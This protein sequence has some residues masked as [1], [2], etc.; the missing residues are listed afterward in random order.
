MYPS[1]KTAFLCIIL[2]PHIGS[3]QN[4]SSAT[5]QAAQG[6]IMSARESNTGS[7]VAVP[8]SAAVCEV[9]SAN[10]ASNDPK[11]SKES[12]DS[13]V[14]T[15]VSVANNT[16]V[17]NSSTKD[18]LAERVNTDVSVGPV[19]A[20]ETGLARLKEATATSDSDR[21]IGPKQNS[22]L[23]NTSK[24]AGATDSSSELDILPSLLPSDFT[25][26][27]VLKDITGDGSASGANEMLPLDVSEIVISCE[28][29]PVESD[30]HTATGMSCDAV[31][32]PSDGVAC[33]SDSDARSSREGREGSAMEDDHR[34]SFRRQSPRKAPTKST[35]LSSLTD[36]SSPNS[37]GMIVHFVQVITTVIIIITVV[38][39]FYPWFKF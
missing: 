26:D 14:T 1:L 38:A 3:E 2:F 25:L 4:V 33:D 24:S 37:S 34:T 13:S 22:E 30:S 31:T 9:T 20:G 35:P 39:Q 36:V 21:L 15:L 17:L 12:A 29:L 11:P 27:N 7:E 28:D 19:D 6:T 10:R 23:T 18:T 32:A 16:S 8:N 5:G